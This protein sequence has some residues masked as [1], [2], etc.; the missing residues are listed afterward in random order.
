MTKEVFLSKR[1]LREY[2]F[3][4]TTSRRRKKL[5]GDAL[6]IER[7]EIEVEQISNDTKSCDKE[8]ENYVDAQQDEAQS[9]ESRMEEQAGTYIGDRNESV[10][11]DEH[12]VANRVEVGVSEEPGINEDLNI[13]HT[14]EGRCQEQNKNGS[15]DDVDIANEQDTKAKR[16]S[17][18]QFVLRLM[19][20]VS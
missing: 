20:H 8:N 19:W 15:N 10:M 14:H 3:R 6:P 13:E 7:D 18:G 16:N 17:M 2:N 4:V 1:P 12:N 5:K 11:E 9:N